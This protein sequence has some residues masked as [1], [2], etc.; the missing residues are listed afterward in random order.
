MTRMEISSG[1]DSKS[2]AVEQIKRDR[3][4][5]TVVCRQGGRLDFLKELIRPFVATSP[6]NLD[7]PCC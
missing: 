6:F 3:V 4:G 5:W 1:L 7:T 2:S